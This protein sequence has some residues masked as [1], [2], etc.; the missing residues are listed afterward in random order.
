LR[1][2]DVDPIDC[3]ETVVEDIAYLMTVKVNFWWSEAA[4]AGSV[5][6][7]VEKIKAN[8]ATKVTLSAG[9]TKFL[10]VNGAV[11]F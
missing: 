5:R 10:K 4:G 11:I 7:G 1:E 8:H 9:K 2:A 6:M 3:H